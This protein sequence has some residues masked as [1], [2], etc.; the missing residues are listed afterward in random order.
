MD[1]EVSQT[2]SALK[3]SENRKEKKK[4]REGWISVRTSLMMIEKRPL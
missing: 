4:E 3:R 2:N 1:V